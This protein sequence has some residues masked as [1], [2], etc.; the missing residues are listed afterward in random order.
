MVECEVFYCGFICSNSPR[1]IQS[2]I[3]DDMYVSGDAGRLADVSMMLSISDQ[4]HIVVVKTSQVG[5]ATLL[6]SH[7]LEWRPILAS[8]HSAMNVSVELKG[9][10]RV[11]G[12]TYRSCVKCYVWYGSHLCRSCF[13]CCVGCGGHP[14]QSYVECYVG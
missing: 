14:Y 12:Q 8:Q 11:L 6:S 13:K 3:V 7:L 2:V 10:G 4:V 9:I 1:H 5:D